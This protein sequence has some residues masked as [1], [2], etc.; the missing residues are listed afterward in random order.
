MGTRFP[1][2]DVSYLVATVFTLGSVIWCINGSFVWLPA[3]APGSTFPTE[4]LYGGGITAFVGATVFELGSILLMVE[5]VNENRAGCFGWA[6]ERALEGG[7]MR[8]RPSGNGCGHHHADRKNFVGSGVGSGKG[9]ETALSSAS[10]DADANT[11]AEKPPPQQDT[12]QER[13][14]QWFPSAHEL[15][16]HYLRDIGFLACLAQLFGAS[17]FWISGFTALPG[18]NN[19]LSQGVLDGIYW[20]PQIVGGM[21]FVVSGYVAVEVFYDDGYGADGMGAGYSS[22]SKR[23]NDGT[24]PRSGCW[25]GTSGSGTW[26]AR[27]ASRYVCLGPETSPFR[28][29]RIRVLIFFLD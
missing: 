26:W 4:I 3:V 10:S 8:L 15:A 18:I 2:W 22:C 20:T 9:E 29:I 14:W 7:R 16:T 11:N 23:R 13:T 1:Y 6:L 12:Q 25:G 27:W 28:F 5:A 17:V 24:C 21:G 19:A